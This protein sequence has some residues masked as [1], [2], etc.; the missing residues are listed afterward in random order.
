MKLIDEKTIYPEVKNEINGAEENAIEKKEE[1]ELK[2][3]T[4]IEGEIK[5]SATPEKEDSPKEEEAPKEEEI[6]KEEIKEEVALETPRKM[7]V[8]IRGFANLQVE[9][10][11][12]FVFK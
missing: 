2:K 8:Q 4:T 11:E 9:F 12:N 6:K 1:I 7:F 3:E 5:R 10:I